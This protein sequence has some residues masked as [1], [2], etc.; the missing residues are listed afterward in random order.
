M[1]WS[2]LRCSCFLVYDLRVPGGLPRFSRSLELSSGLR[3]ATALGVLAGVAIAA[4]VF[5]ALLSPKQAASQAEPVVHGWVGGPQASEFL[6]AEARLDRRVREAEEAALAARAA[7][8][9]ARDAK[10]DTLSIE[11]YERRLDMLGISPVERL[12]QIYVSEPGPAPANAEAGAETN[13]KAGDG[14]EEHP[15]HIRPVVERTRDL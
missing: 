14:D 5:G 3:L 4:G 10:V 1:T 6:G 12:R 11:R 2:D 13:A 15:P 9:R 7:L 8:S